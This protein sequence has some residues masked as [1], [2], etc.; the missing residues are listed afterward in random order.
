MHVSLEEILSF[1][2]VP[3]LGATQAL[4]RLEVGGTGF[5]TRSYQDPDRRNTL[6]S[7][8]EDQKHVK[9]CG[10]GVDYDRKPELM[11]LMFEEEVVTLA[12]LG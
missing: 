2:A 5:P 10:K 4:L 6:C 12:L 1:E 11:K 9:P 7:R 3:G 8:G